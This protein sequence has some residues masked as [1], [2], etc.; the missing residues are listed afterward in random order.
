V[1]SDEWLVASGAEKNNVE[2]Q[3]ALGFRRGGAEVGVVTGE[4][5]SAP[6]ATL[7]GFTWTG[8]VNEGP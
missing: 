2:T 4:V 7:P 3:R 8:R 5:A 1:A 6:S